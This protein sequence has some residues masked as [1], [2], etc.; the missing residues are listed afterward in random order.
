MKLSQKAI[1]LLAANPQ[2]VRMLALALDFTETWIRVLMER[3]AVNG[4]LT[5]AAALE[6]FRNNTELPEAEVL[7]KETPEP[8]TSAT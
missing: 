6:V 2:L 3:N 4:Y 5:T 8:I 7:V 1:D